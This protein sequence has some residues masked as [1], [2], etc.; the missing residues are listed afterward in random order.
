MPLTDLKIRSTKPGDKPIKLP[1]GHGLY[2]EVRPT[3]SKLWRYRY[4]IAG[5]EN[6]FAIGEY[7][8]VTLQDARQAHSDLYLGEAQET[9]RHFSSWQWAGFR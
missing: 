2:L 1:D 8:A 5:K 6:T 7:P 3:G 4:K 9:I